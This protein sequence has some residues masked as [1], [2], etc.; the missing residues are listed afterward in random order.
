ML[1]KILQRKSIQESWGLENEASSKT[2]NLLSTIHFDSLIYRAE[3]GKLHE[4]E[5][6]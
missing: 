4:T 3:N 2:Q 1:I 5:L 6:L